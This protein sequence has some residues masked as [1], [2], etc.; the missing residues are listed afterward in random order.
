MTYLVFPL[1]MLMVGAAVGFWARPE[2]EVRTV[3]Q[4]QERVV[5]KLVQVEQEEKVR[6]VVRNRIVER[7]I[8]KQ[9][10][11][12]T[13]TTETEKSLNTEKESGTTTTVQE[14]DSSK[15]NDTVFLTETDTRKYSLGAKY[16]ADFQAPL[17]PLDRFRRDRLELIGG[18]KV[19]PGVW[20]EAGL[21]EHGFSLGV[22]HDF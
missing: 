9:P 17:A 15:K 7:V 3:T 19:L 6:V 14:K 10:D 12:T 4:V 1:T 11:G 13:T 18:T 5:E 2:P 22:R 21:M 16:W 20:L 8:V